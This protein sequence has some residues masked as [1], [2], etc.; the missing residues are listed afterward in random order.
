M[1]TTSRLARKVEF[2][3][4]Q[5]PIGLARRV[6][7]RVADLGFA[8][9]SIVEPSC[10]VGNLLF[11][12]ADRFPEFQRAVGIEVQPRYLETLGER[13]SGRA[14]AERI[15][16][17]LANFFAHDW[18][19]AL[20]ALPGPLLVIG[21]P[22]WVTN[23]QLS[24]GGSGNLPEKS[25][26]QRHAGMDA[27]TGKSNF[28]ISEAMLL[29]LSRL[30]AS[31]DAVLAMLCKTNVA[32]KVLVHIWQAGTPI[33]D[34]AL[35]RIDSAAEFGAAVD[36][37]LFTC[38]F[39]ATVTDQT[40]RVFPSLGATAPSGRIGFR[41]GRLLANADMHDRWGH[42]EGDEVYRWRSGIKHDCADVCEL[43]GT[44][45]AWRTAGGAAVDVEPDYIYPMLKA[46][47][48]GNGRV[49]APRRWMIVTQ[50]SVGEDTSKIAA[51]APRTWAYLQANAARFE[52]RASVIYR[53][54]PPF[55]MFGIGEYSFALW[56]VGIAGLYKKIDF[57]VIGPH[58]GKAVVL[59]D[60]GYFVPCRSQEEAEL[61]A[62]L[63]NSDAAREFYSAF[64][65]WDAKRPIT[66]ELLRRLDLRR[67]AAAL[68][69]SAALEQV[70][71]AG[72]IYADCNV[73][74]SLWAK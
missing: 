42:L 44:P 15:T 17:T 1:E 25:N 72:A 33:R 29:R 27:I 60:T 35:H 20:A 69:K 34:A 41:D 39:G 11:A 26:F 10:G 62:D 46:S 70:L 53:N 22:P 4:F 56:K 45:G 54:R 24:A 23:A 74:D 2:G 9:A 18:S 28:D 16:L 67:V 49:H 59:D 58:A 68:G 57:K 66:V 7:D 6:A 65:F 64:A 8:P 32:R 51:A 61:V 55:S 36:A 31:R 30:L 21:N 19:V 43:E 48:L 47:D 12:A 73:A 52:R 3:D 38:R 50:R 40:A 63:L 5:T 14:D 37:C 13:R 71:T